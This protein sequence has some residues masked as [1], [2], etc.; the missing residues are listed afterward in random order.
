VTLKEKIHG[1]PAEQL[2]GK[3]V[4]KLENKLSF[5]SINAIKLATSL[6]A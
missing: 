3:N 6:G 1:S 2:S 4:Q 5:S